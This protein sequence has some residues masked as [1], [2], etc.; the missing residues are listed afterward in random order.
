MRSSCLSARAKHAIDSGE[1]L[2]VRA[3]NI[4]SFAVFALPTPSPSP[5][6]P[7]AEARASSEFEGGMAEHPRLNF[8]SLPPSRWPPCRR[9]SHGN[10]LPPLQCLLLP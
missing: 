8:P 1:D 9:P 5:R 3:L 10:E 6:T 2:K 7:A 4:E